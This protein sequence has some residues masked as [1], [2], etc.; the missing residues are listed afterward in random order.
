MAYKTRVKCFAKLRLEFYANAKRAIS[1]NGWNFRQPGAK[2]PKKSRRKATGK[3]PPV[4]CT[5][6]TIDARRALS[7]SIV[8]RV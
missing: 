6:L 4:S 2:T 7:I 5:D 3:K 1:T 8:H